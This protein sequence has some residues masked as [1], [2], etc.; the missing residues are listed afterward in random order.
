M[1]AATSAVILSGTNL[2]D[3]DD[4]RPGLEA[5]RRRAVRHPYV[6]AGID[7]SG[8]RMIAR[9]LGLD[10]LAELPAAPCLSSRIETGV[11]IEA[12]LLR[13]VDRAERAIR[14]AVAAPVVRTRV[15]EDRIDVELDADSLSR[16]RV[17]TASR[18]AGQVEALATEEGIAL[19]VRL[20]PY[21]RGS[22]FLRPASDA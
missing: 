13:F 10:D 7:K 6:E 16:L 17:E 18:L 11:R 14:D 15:R 5:A 4:Y 3:L 20:A 9:A 2:D 1:R 21:R 8:V 19:P 22:A 12:N